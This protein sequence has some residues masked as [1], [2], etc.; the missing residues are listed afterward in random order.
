[1]QFAIDAFAKR[2][3]VQDSAFPTKTNRLRQ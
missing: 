2:E 3:A 1:M